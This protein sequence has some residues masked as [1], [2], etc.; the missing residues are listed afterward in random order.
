MRSLPS[1]YIASWALASGLAWVLTRALRNYALRSNILDHPND[2]S[3]H[4]VPTPRGGGVAIV[5]SFL[6]CTAALALAE[7]TS[8][9]HAVA[10]LGAGS[11]VAL[12][13]FLDDR[14]PLPARYRFVGHV[15]G[16]AWVVGWMSPLPP[17][18]L[19]GV[20]MDLG[21]AGVA[22]GVVCIVWSINLFNFM[23]GIDGIASIEAITVS[24]GGALVCWLAGTSELWPIAALLAACV[25]GFLVW[26]YPPARIFMGDAGSG[27]LGLVLAS[28]ALWS[29]SEQPQLLWA[30]SV[31][32][33]VF[34]VDATTT[35]VR[36]VRRGEL[37]FEAHR[38][39]AY[40]YASR[41]HA[42]HERVSLAV[43][44]INVGWLLPIACAIA[45]G[46]V[47]GLLGLLVAYT[48][49]VAL[50]YH[51]KAGDRRGQGV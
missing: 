1:I 23:D 31:L 16:A 19:L 35:L 42:S 20:N 45:T 37:F 10:L 26:N 30:W 21:L 7:A 27:F 12:L 48:P 6:I 44:L 5:L 18:P 24:L 3:S 8:E 39:H 2:R 41:K 4:L 46:W 40:Q 43:G 36:R 50:A 15:A 32:Y 33:G 28:L 25:A 9:R 17:V 13:G 49:L 11:L 34:I 14:K 22:L 51:Y 29:A 47:D 38:S